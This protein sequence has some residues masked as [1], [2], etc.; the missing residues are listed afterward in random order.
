[1][2]RKNFTEFSL[3][4]FARFKVFSWFSKQTDI[5]KYFDL[6]VT[7]IFPF[8]RFSDLTPLNMT[9]KVSVLLIA[10]VPVCQ[11]L[12]WLSSLTWVQS[13]AFFARSSS[14]FFE[15]GSGDWITN[16]NFAT[17]T[18]VF[19]ATYQ[20]KVMSGGQIHKSPTHFRCW[21]ISFRIFQT[22]QGENSLILTLKAI[23][24]VSVLINA[25]EAS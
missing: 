22:K 9:A 6:L 5:F 11:T 13:T 20:Q 1:M 3:F 15:S 8:F 7:N 18:S 4:H 21:Q 17:R 10:A 16:Y 12:L 19:L 24:N 25:S 2:K 23:L 14:F